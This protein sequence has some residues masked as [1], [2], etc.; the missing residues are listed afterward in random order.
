MSNHTEPMLNNSTHFAISAMMWFEKVREGS[1]H[2]NYTELVQKHPA[3][4]ASP[5]NV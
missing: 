5:R 2:V 4:L 1:M 3:Q